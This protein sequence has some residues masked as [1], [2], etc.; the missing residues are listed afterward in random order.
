MQVKRIYC[1]WNKG[2]L[3]LIV[4]LFWGTYISAQRGEERTPPRVGGQS[5][6]GLTVPSVTVV[7][8]VLGQRLKMHDSTL[9]GA[10]R[11]ELKFNARGQGK[12]RTKK[13]QLELQV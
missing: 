1:T 9:S 12:N 7:V 8:R 6:L 11:K 5:W 2:K 10:F 3:K 4:F 13:T